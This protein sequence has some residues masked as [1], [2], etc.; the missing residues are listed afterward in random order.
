MTHRNAVTTAVKRT[1][2]MIDCDGS[3]REELL[4]KN[5]ERKVTLCLLNSFCRNVE[6]NLNPLPCWKQRV[7]KRG[8]GGLPPIEP[9]WPPLWFKTRKQKLQSRCRRRR[10]W[11]SDESRLTR[12]KRK[13][14]RI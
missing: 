11:S 2:K 13:I 4:T 6:T 5:L 8:V 9:E 10:I 1:L 14:R 3:E 7:K 12:C